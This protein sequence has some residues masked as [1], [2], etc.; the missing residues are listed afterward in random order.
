MFSMLLRQEIRSLMRK[1]VGLQRI[2]TPS[3]ELMTPHA[4]DMRRLRARRARVNTPVGGRLQ[5][6]SRPLAINWPVSAL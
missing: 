5:D 4:T 6:I 2:S 3:H 1:R